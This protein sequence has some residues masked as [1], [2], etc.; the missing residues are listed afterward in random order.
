MIVATG[1]HGAAV[2]KIVNEARRRGI[3]VRQLP[4]DVLDHLADG[5]RHQGV[6]AKAS[7]YEYASYSEL[8]VDL[9]DPSKSA[10]VLALDSITDPRNFGALLRTAEAVGIRHVLIP[11][12][13]SVGVT[14]AVVK[15]SAGAVDYLK[16][17]RV[18]NLRQALK[19]LKEQGFWVV[20]LDPKAARNLYDEV[21]PERLIVVLGAE[22]TGVRPLIQKECDFLVAIP[23]RGQIE[24]LNVAVSGA[25][26]LY[27]LVGRGLR[28]GG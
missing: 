6:A 20:G 26:F 17:Y 2:G 27:E 19:S 23:M 7:S 13:R 15:A 12:D 11:K 5:G 16:I 1:R 14:G 9:A 3:R 24:S 22:G 28:Q 18:T 21:Y 25:V 8:L 4:A 10:W